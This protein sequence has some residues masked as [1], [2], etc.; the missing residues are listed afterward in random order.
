MHLAMGTEAEAVIL[1][2]IIYFYPGHE[3]LF[4]FQGDERKSIT[5]VVSKVRF[6]FALLV[7]FIVFIQLQ[8]LKREVDQSKEQTQSYKVS[9]VA[10]ETAIKEPYSLLLLK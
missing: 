4:F 10:T 6:V 3:L 8:N 2:R 5:A 7:I 9:R 1:V